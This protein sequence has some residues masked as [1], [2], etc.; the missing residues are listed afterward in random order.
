LTFNVFTAGRNR[1]PT[2]NDTM[3]SRLESLPGVEA[4]GY[5]ELMPMV[6]FRVSGP[7]LRRASDRVAVPGAPAP[8]MHVVTPG[9]LK[10]MRV[11]VI[12]GRMLDD[13]DAP[14]QTPVV[15]INRALA[16]SGFL[17]RS[18]VGAQ[19]Y[20][21]IRDTAWQV[22]GVVEDVRQQGLDQEPLPQIFVSARQ[23][24]MGN[25]TPYFAV[26][27]RG[28]PTDL[29]SAVRNAVHDVDS[30]A[31]VD[32]VA[33]LEAVVSNS[34]ARQR[35]FAL[36]LSVFA[37]IAALLAAVGIYGVVAYSVSRRTREIGVRMAI[38]AD[39]AS[40]IGLVLGQSLALTAVGLVIGLAGAVAV[41]RYLEQ[42]LFGLTSLDAMT[43]AGVSVAFLLVALAASWLPAYRAAAVGPLSALRSQ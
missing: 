18:A 22:V 23:F 15:L 9:Y 7:P 19:I 28:E 3:L 24:P 13:R 39:R 30:E 40:V 36:M 38:G 35:L 25:P 43:F 32:N 6:R 11:R 5:A 29:L 37:L 27:A 34:L 2:F 4:A 20:P 26:R 14:G 41:S 33:T 31:V 10:A 1:L 12:E 17:G 42:L 8:Q 16:R 21:T